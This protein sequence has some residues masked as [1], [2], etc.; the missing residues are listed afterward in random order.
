VEL[1]IALGLF[2][3][4]LVLFAAT[5]QR[6]RSVAR[7]LDGLLREE[8]VAA[9]LRPLDASE[10]LRA[11]DEQLKAFRDQFAGLPRPLAAGDL[12][13]L[14]ERIARFEV[15]LGDLRI[16]I[17]EQRARTAYTSDDEGG[18]PGR[19]RRTLAQ[20]GFEMIHVLADVIEGAT[21][22]ELRIPVEARRA[23]MT[24]KGTVTVADGRVTDVAL[25]PANE[26]FP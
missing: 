3:V 19:M 26:V 25:K 10:R 18:L 4:A 16:R 21:A 22:E 13:P 2:A 20:H 1:W 12:A 11:I 24:F 14:A 8:Q 7:R 5:L 17:D 6:I 15:I 9:L 23:G